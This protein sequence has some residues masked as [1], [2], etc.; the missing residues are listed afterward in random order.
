MATKKDISI[1]KHLFTML[2]VCA[3]LISWS[4]DFYRLVKEDSLNREIVLAAKEFTYYGIDFSHF[5]LVNGKKVGDEAVV[6]EYISTWINLVNKRFIINDKLEYQ[7]D[8]K[9]EDLQEYVQHLHFE[10]KDKWITYTRTPLLLDSVQK[11]IYTTAF[12]KAK[13][14]IGLVAIVGALDKDNESAYVNFVFFDT[15]TKEILWRLKYEGYNKNSG[16]MSSRWKKGL[17]T[18]FNGFF[19]YL[20]KETK[21]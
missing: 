14:Q 1:S 10:R 13:N 15:S 7:T 19:K 3:P 4:Q 6:L 8:R 2:L 21:R 18:C 9:I 17:N 11:I 16:G 20:R 12:P 5:N